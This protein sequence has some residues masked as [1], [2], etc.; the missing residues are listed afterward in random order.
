[1]KHPDYPGVSS[2]TD[3]HGKVRWRVRKAGKAIYLPGEPHT[4]KF[5]GIYQAAVRG[6]VIEKPAREYQRNPHGV[7]GNFPHRIDRM[8]RQLRVRSA[9]L[10]RE[11]DLSHEWLIAELERCDY[12]CTLTGIPFQADRI[13]GKRANPF[14]PSIDRIDNSRGYTP[15]NVRLVLTSV[16]LALSDFGLD[17]LDEICRARVTKLL[18]VLAKGG[19]KNG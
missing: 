5:D 15:D 1:V 10:R 2:M 18:A 13:D 19:K 11:F 3:R 4:P 9:S 12:R 16:N 6:D 8:L 14:A 17:H 7:R